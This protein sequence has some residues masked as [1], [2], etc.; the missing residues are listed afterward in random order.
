MTTANVTPLLPTDGAIYANG[1][2]LTNTEGDLN[3]LTGLNQTPIGVGLGNALYL[4]ASIKIVVAG[5]PG[6]GVAWVAIQT[7]L[8]DGIWYDVGWVEKSFTLGN[9]TF[10]QAFGSGI[11]TSTSS[12]SANNWVNARTLGVDPGATGTN[13]LPLGGQLR[14]TGKTTFNQGTATVTIYYKLQGMR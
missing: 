3:N 13:N 5:T 10:N 14:F 6:S 12:A 8:A 1:T 2:V 4:L 7:A 9:G 11:M